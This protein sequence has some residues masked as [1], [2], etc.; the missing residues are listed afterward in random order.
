MNNGLFGLSSRGNPDDNKNNYIATG[1]VPYRETPSTINYYCSAVGQYSMNISLSASRIYFLPF[2]V[3]KKQNFNEIGFTG[4]STV[5]TRTG[6]I[7]IYS[8]FKNLPRPSNL[9]LDAGSFNFVAASTIVSFNIDITLN[10][11]WYWI[12]MLN[13][14]TVSYGGSSSFINIGGYARVRIGNSSYNMNVCSVSTTSTTFIP[15]TETTLLNA[16]SAGPLINL[17]ASS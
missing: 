12:A 2:Y 16:E 13:R 8:S 6:R 1:F 14:N 7:G 15:V 4:G 10:K 3:D 11:G 17:K 9:I 5:G